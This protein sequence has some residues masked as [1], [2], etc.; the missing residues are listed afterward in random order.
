MQQI[1]GRTVKVNF[2]KVP[3][4]G[5]REAMRLKIRKSN[6]EFIESQHKIYEGKFFWI[7]TSKKLKDALADEPGLF[8]AKVI[9][10][11]HSGRSHDFGFVTFS[12]LEADES[13]LSAMEG[14]VRLSYARAMIELRPDV[15]LKD[16]IVVAM[17]EITRRLPTEVKNKREKDKIGTKPDQIKKKGKRPT[18][19]AR[20]GDTVIVDVINRGD[21]NITIHWHG[22]KQPRY[23]WSDGPEFVTQCPIKPGGNFT[24]MVFLSDEEGTLWW[25]AHSDWSRATVHGLIY[26]LPRLGTT[27]PFRQPDAEVPM[28][29]GEW[30]NDDIQNV[31]EEF[32]SSGA[33]PAN[34]DALTINGQPGDLYNCSAAGTTRIQVESG[35]TYL[36]RMVNAAMNNIAFFGVA[37][38]SLTVVGTD[39]AYTKPLTSTYVAISPGQ[40]LDILLEANQPRNHYYIASKLFNA[41]RG[42]T[43]DNTTTTAIVEYAG[44]YTATSPPIFPV[45]PAF[46]SSNASFNFTASLRS[47]ASAEHPIDVPLTIKRTLLYTLSIN[48]LPCAVNGTCER[49]DGNRFAASINNITFDMPSTSILEAY[50][51]GAN[52]GTYG[53]DFP[54]N[55]PLKFNYTQQTGLNA[56]WRFPETGT[57]VQQLKHNETVELVFQGTNLVGGVDHPMHLHGHSFYVVGAGF[58]N[59]KRSRDVANY[60]LVDPPLMQTIAVPQN[61][62][63]AIR[64]KAD[65]PG[66]WFMHCHLERHVSWGMGMVFI[67]RNGKTRNARVLPPPP[68]MPPC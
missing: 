33:D 64:F 39:G 1:S 60:N 49:P 31:F 62:W 36:L 8:S 40:T 15:E 6:K 10:E 52:N 14:I 46:N 2:P 34:S 20:R 59:F 12:Y 56:S 48:L 45:L 3:R 9:Y 25:H 44:N 54:D 5:E 22:V 50:Y 17:P 26:I 7:V 41:Q 18:I 24:Q 63:T 27:Y 47:L 43:F 67:V 55:P 21:H 58:G 29:I 68:D 35:K 28:I 23:P 42:S 11:K 16:N 19:T 53:E 13:A 66:V 4:G 61:G 57:D 37:N 51:R 65:N 38:H 32:M 30:W